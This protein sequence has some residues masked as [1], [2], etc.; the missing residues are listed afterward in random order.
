MSAP[1]FCVFDGGIGD[2]GA[3][4]PRRPTTDDL[5]GDAKQ[6]NYEFPPD[7]VEHFTAGGWNQL[8][9]VAKAL[10]K[11]AALCKLELGFDAGAPFVA[12]APA[13]SGNVTLATFTVTDNGTG[14]TTVTWPANTFPPA[15]CAPTGLTLLSSLTAVLDGHVERVT[16][17]I[18]VRTKSAGSAAD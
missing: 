4:P 7:D 18:R 2:E 9:K 5:G 15:A 11:T 1:E 17:G 12:A 6:D 8:V 10:S 14:D 16:N 13:L 3:E